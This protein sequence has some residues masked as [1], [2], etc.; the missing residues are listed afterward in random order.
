MLF[1]STC[2]DVYMLRDLQWRTRVAGQ[3]LQI[4]IPAGVTSG[5]A[6]SVTV[7][8]GPQLSF[9]VPPGSGPGS[10]LQLWYDPVACTVSPLV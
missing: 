1:L 5:Q 3:V 7:P 10:E 6:L 2:T 8:D 9:T 4:V